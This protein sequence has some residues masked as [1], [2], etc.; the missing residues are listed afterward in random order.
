MKWTNVDDD[1]LLLDELTLRPLTMRHHYGT[2]IDALASF[3]YALAVTGDV[4]RW[5]L[6]N[7]S[8]DTLHKVP[9]PHTPST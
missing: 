2:E 9:S 7:A 8:I 5:M 3:D 1:D 6:N 4:F